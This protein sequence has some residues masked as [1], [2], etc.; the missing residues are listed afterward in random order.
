MR[1][2]ARAEGE[3]TRAVVFAD[4]LESAPGAAQ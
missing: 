3:N 1:L 2:A 4:N